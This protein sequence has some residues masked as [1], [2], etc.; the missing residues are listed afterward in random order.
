MAQTTA[1]AITLHRRGLRSVV[2]LGQEQHKALWSQFLGLESTDVER[3]TISTIDEFPYAD[4]VDEMAPIPFNTLSSPYS[5]NV[6]PVLRALAFTISVQAKFTDAY[7]KMQKAG[8][9][10]TQ[11]MMATREYNAANVLNL[12][13]TAPGSGGTATMDGVNLFSASHTLASGVDSNLQ[14]SS[15]LAIATFESLLALARTVSSHK[16]KPSMYDGKFFL[17]VPPELEGLGFRLVNANGQP[18]NNHNDPNWAGPLCDLMVNPYLSSTTSY[19]AVPKDLSRSGLKRMQQLALVSDV[20]S[21][22]NPPSHEF[23]CYESDAYY[24]EDW[25]FCAAGQS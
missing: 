1:N 10:M 20:T 17:V 7:G 15:A 11:S 5:M 21:E 25:R 24:A 4:T 9:K 3:E 18:Q 2:D 16:G 22:N 23:T 8:R 19:F 12:G 13:F 14:T 6:T